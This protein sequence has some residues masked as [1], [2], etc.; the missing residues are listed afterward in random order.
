MLLHRAKRVACILMGC[1]RTMA[2]HFTT[3]A[4]FVRGERHVALHKAVLMCA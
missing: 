4:A 3:H 2:S 1:L